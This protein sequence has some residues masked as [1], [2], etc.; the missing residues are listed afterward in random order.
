M[1]AVIMMV[2]GLGTAAGPLPADSESV[3]AAAWPFD[4]SDGPTLAKL[5]PGHHFARVRSIAKDSTALLRRADGST[6]TG[7]RDPC[8]SDMRGSSKNPLVRVS[9]FAG[10]DPTGRSDSTA[11]F[12]AAMAV[13]LARG[14]RSG[15]K[16]ADNVTDLGGCELSSLAWADVSPLLGWIRHA[17]CFG[18]T[19][20][21]LG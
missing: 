3:Q 8:S 9:S 15:Y 7:C 20:F 4:L 11:A 13:V 5:A 12:A 14:Q 18:C 16:M 6:A 2:H 1:L 19:I 17:H 10:A 21:F